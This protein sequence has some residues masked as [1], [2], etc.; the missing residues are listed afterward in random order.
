M[1]L[2]LK[3]T[4]NKKGK[5]YTKSE[6]D[7]G[8]R[9]QLKRSRFIKF[10]PFLLLAFVIWLQQTLQSEVLRSIYIPL[11]YDSVG[12]AY[13]IEGQIP[14][15]LELQVRDK[16][17]EHIRYSFSGFDTLQL[18]SFVDE[19]RQER[20]IGLEA[21]DLEDLSFSLFSETATVLQMSFNELK[22]PIRE[23]A[24]KKVPIRFEGRPRPVGG[25]MISHLSLKP[26]SLLI[27][28]DAERLKQIKYIGTKPWADSI[29]RVSSQAYL[30]LDLPR[31]VHSTTRQV[32]VQIDLEELTQ[33]SYTIPIEV[34][35][36]PKGYKITLLPSTSSVLLTIPRNRFND[37]KEED[38]RL[39]ADYEAGVDEGELFVYLEQAPEWIVQAHITNPVVQFIKERTRL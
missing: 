39:V 28:T 30:S 2:G 8:W 31:G 4:P 33:Q 1:E 32:L 18:K 25:Y 15:H 29:V 14:Q 34:I 37:I 10:V 22:I 27:Y 38:L 9:K 7:Q 24:K 36:A 3:I 12:I 35:N 11:S 6:N 5:R 26:D 23:R 21:K 20:Y 16:G 17:W 13:N 19:E